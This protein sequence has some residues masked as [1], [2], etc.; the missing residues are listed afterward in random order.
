MCDVLQPY[1]LCDGLQ[2]RQRHHV[3]LITDSDRHQHQSPQEAQDWVVLC[4]W[5]GFVQCKLLLQPLFDMR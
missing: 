1:D 4:F 5:L 2:H 3:D